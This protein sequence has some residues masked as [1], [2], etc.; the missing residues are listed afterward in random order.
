VQIGPINEIRPVAMPTPAEGPAD[1]GKV[2]AVE[3]RHQGRGAEESPNQKASRGLEEDDAEESAGREE[4]EAE[5]GGAPTGTI[6]LI[7]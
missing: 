7:A 5:A 3:L 6:N 1:L 4:Q 2:F